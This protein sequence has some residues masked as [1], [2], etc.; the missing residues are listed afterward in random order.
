MAEASRATR[1]SWPT[2]IAT[3][4]RPTDPGEVKDRKLALLDDARSAASPAAKQPAPG[5]PPAGL[6]LAG[7]PLAGLTRL[8][9]PS[10][11]RA[12]RMQAADAV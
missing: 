1:S 5:L 6:P 11:A 12:I 10:S 7:L 9:N 2:L 8:R 4:T 3:V